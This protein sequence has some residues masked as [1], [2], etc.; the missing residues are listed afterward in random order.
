M[1]LNWVGFLLS[2]ATILVISKR[3]LPL[4][5][6]SGA[7][8][9]GLL[10]LPVSAVIHQTTRTLT[11]RSIV[12]LALAMGVIPVI[13]GTMKESGQIDSLLD[14]V[15][16]N[17]RYLLATSAAFM[18]LL[19]MP[20][21][22]LL[23]APILEKGGEGVPDLLKAAINNWFRHLFILVYPLSPAL[24]ASSEIVNVDVY[25]AM[26]YLLPSLTLATTLGYLFFLRR[27][28]GRPH[29]SETFSWP[30]FLLPLSI[31]LSAPILD[32]TLK[33][34]AGLGSEATVI[35]VAAALALSVA[36][37]QRPLAITDIV[38]RTR[39]WN[40]ALIIIGMFL[41]LHVFQQSEASTLIASLPL[42]PLIL[43]VT[44]GFLL[45]LFTGRVQL[46]ASIILPVYLTSAG[47][48]TPVTFALIYTAI[49][50]GYVISPVHPCL[51]VTSEYFHTP[52]KD[53]MLK[54]TP[55]T[56]IILAVV[57]FV[58]LFSP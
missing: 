25:S 26:L 41:Y 42:P 18:G 44:V 52:V 11:D 43:A 6:I 33:R 5:L 27:V 1:L 39:P 46:P 23:S 47:A 13:G 20:G 16:M 40:F 51:V 38:T 9:L 28:H 32:F 57:L 49:F 34:L 29:Y 3:N 58:S 19:P 30:G 7:L 54:L 36:F 56:A 55:A 15:R 14:N 50:F 17:R 45:G 4:A 21:G 10:T 35:G 2:L 12:L 8:L 24:I 37:S 53:L 22:A 31:I 48:I